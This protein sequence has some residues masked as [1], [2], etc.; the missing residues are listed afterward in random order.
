MNWHDWKY[1]SYEELGV[2]LSKQL[3]TNNSQPESNRLDSSK[4]NV[5]LIMRLPETNRKYVEYKMKE[6]DDPF[7]FA[8]D[9]LFTMLHGFRFNKHIFFYG[10]IRETLQRLFE[11]G[12]LKCSSFLKFMRNKDSIVV[13]EK[14]TKYS[15]LTW[16]QL[17][18]GF[19][20]WLGASVLCVIVFIVEILVFEVEVRYS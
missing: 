13:H 19:Y 14:Q 11:S 18:P 16:D 15:T 1:I 5:L 3:I 6:L 2:Q 7:K 12:I 17:Y 10:A 20:I 4:K 9:N 8:T